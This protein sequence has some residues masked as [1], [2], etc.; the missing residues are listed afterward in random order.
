MVEILRL[1]SERLLQFWWWVRRVH[2][3]MFIHREVGGA[4]LMAPLL[5]RG[6]FF[7]TKGFE[8]NVDANRMKLGEPPPSAIVSITR[9]PSGKV[10]SGVTFEARRSGPVHT[11]WWVNIWDSQT[12]S[13]NRGNL[14]SSWPD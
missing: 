13:Q 5:A 14:W 3:K 10:R 1:S 12:L 11:F 9:L 6:G 7:K 8:F 4:R 2:Q